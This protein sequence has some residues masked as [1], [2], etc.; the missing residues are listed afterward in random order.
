MTFF[1][2]LHDILRIIL[3]ELLEDFRCQ[4]SGRHPH[5]S[6]NSK[7]VFESVLSLIFFAF[8]IR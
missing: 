1:L 4:T 2:F 6:K 3:S 8:S 5:F 7:L